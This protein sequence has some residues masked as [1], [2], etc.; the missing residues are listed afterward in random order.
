VEL[1]TVVHSRPGLSPPRQSS[2]FLARIRSNSRVFYRKERLSIKTLAERF[3]LGKARYYKRFGRYAKK[4][5]VF[6]PEVGKLYLLMIWKPQDY[7][8]QLIVLMTTLHKGIQERL[9]V[10]QLL[11]EVAH[12][13]FKHNLGLSKRQYRK[14]AAQLKHADLILTAF[15]LVWAEKAHGPP[16]LSWQQAQHC[17]A[18]FL[19]YQLLTKSNLLSA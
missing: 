12:R 10:W 7:T 11:A 1:V 14:F 2:P 5:R 8:F 3:R 16:G 15:H 13:L 4:R 19:K 9:Q 17:A 18:Q 6:L